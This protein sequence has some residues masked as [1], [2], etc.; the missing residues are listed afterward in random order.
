MV[1][2]DLAMV[3]TGVRFP[4]PAPTNNIYKYYQNKTFT[5]YYAKHIISKESTTRITKKTKV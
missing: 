2:H 3:E 1:A 4:Y 5:K